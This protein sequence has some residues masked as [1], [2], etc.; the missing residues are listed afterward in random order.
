VLLCLRLLSSFLIWFLNLFVNN[1][2]SAGTGA[3]TGA[4]AAPAVSAGVAAVVHGLSPVYLYPAIVMISC[5]LLL[6]TVLI[7]TFSYPNN[8]KRIVIASN[9]HRVLF[10][11]ADSRLVI[12]RSAEAT[13]RERN[14]R[15]SVLAC[16]LLTG[17][18]AFCVARAL[19]VI[20]ATRMSF[21]FC[22]ATG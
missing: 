1:T 13:Q 18:P 3:G 7:K 5:S 16:V 10:V 4:G 21:S 11:I 12:A 19:C 22:A 14:E 15:V 17:R 9:S 6:G 8:G 2:G 20:R